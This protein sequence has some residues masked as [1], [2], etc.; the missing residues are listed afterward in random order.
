[1]VINRIARPARHTFALSFLN[2]LSQ[3]PKKKFFRKMQ[4]ET[5]QLIYSS[6][7]IYYYDKFKEFSKPDRTSG[8]QP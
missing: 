4:T 3:T 7:K 1:M 8:Q 6:F 5:I 2:I